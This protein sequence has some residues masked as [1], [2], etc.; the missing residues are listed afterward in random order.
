MSFSTLGRLQGYSFL[1]GC[2]I[3]DLCYLPIFE[4]FLEKKII[5][6]VNINI[7]LIKTLPNLFFYS[8]NSMNFNEKFLTLILFSLLQ[9]YIK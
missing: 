8:I 9:G 1:S 6:K 2:I 7:D 5:L 4:Y 3:T